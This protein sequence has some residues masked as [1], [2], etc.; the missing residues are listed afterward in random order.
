MWGG[1]GLPRDTK[2][3]IH[4]PVGVAPRGRFRRPVF[5]GP[6]IVRVLSGRKQ[7]RVAFHAVEVRSRFW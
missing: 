6:F 3:Q 4:G 5:L 7:L 2:P 1:A